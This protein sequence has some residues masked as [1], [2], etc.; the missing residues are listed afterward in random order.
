MTSFSITVQWGAVACIDRNGNIT[1]YSVRYGVQGS[2]VGNKTVGHSVA[3]ATI[4]GLT[5]STEYTLEVA[6]VNSAGI[7][8]YSNPRHQLTLGV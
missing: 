5:P 1:G 7:G 3:E 2:A 8:V 6:A 4:S